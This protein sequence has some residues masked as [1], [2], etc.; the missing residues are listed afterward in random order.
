MTSKLVPELPA[1]LQGRILQEAAHISLED[2]TIHLLLV[3]RMAYDR[4]S[5][6][7]YK[8][9]LIEELPQLRAF[10]SLIEAKGVTFLAL[11]TQALFIDIRWEA[12][13][14]LP[15][16]HRIFASVISNLHSLKYLEVWAGHHGSPWIE[17][18][19]KAV[20]GSWP[21][22]SNLTYIATNKSFL[23]NAQKANKTP[24]FWSVTHLKRASLDSTPESHLQ[25]LKSFPNVTH[26]MTAVD[27]SS[28]TFFRKA[29]ALATEL[30]YLKVL[31]VGQ[32]RITRNVERK[33][34]FVKSFPN[35]VIQDD[36]KLFGRASEIRFKEIALEEGGDIWS[37]AEEEI[38][39]RKQ[40][41]EMQA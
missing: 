31:V 34:L 16:L 21:S 38:E 12:A 25:L 2:E 35:L 9:F 17:R 3:S 15:L 6:I 30:S 22:L 39:L 24:I 7:A 5:Y 37:L 4:V 29:S 14:S 11:R 23:E 28:S 10:V 19:Q 40:S 18:L 8:I 41:A 33:N 20:L 1:E 32:Q 26:L 27:S 13:D 36:D